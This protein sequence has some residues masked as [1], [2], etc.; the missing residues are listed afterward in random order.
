MRKFY[1]LSFFFFLLILLNGCR[2]STPDDRITS[3]D[4]EVS[5]SFGSIVIT[6]EDIKTPSGDP[7]T[8]EAFYALL[9][10]DTSGLRFTSS[11]TDVAPVFLSF[12]SLISDP[13]IDFDQQAGKI[14]LNGHI[15]LHTGVYAEGQ[16]MGDFKVFRHDRASIQAIALDDSFN[17]SKSVAIPYLNLSLDQQTTQ[18]TFEVFGNEAYG[19]GSL[20]FLPSFDYLANERVSMLTSIHVNYDTAKSQAQTIATNDT[21]SLVVWMVPVPD[22]DFGDSHLNTLVLTHEEGLQFRF[23]GTRSAHQMIDVAYTFYL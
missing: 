13:H 19:E 22:F 20:A 5:V 3:I 10:P 12:A 7:L 1:V 4:F 8:F 9:N 16:A 6:I 15:E 14:T 17:E 21:G 11:Q 2:P 23:E 18:L